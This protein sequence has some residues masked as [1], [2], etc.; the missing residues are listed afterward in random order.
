MRD[1]TLQF[2][3]RFTTPYCDSYKISVFSPS[4][5]PGRDVKSSKS[6]DSCDNPVHANDKPFDK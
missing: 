1:K 2:K 3:W 4:Y 5:S 6:M